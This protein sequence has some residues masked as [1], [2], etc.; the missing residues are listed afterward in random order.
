MKWTRVSCN[1]GPRLLAGALVLALSGLM[2]FAAVAGRE[3]PPAVQVGIDAGDIGR[4][5][6][7]RVPYPLGFHAKGFDGRIDDPKA[8]WTG[9]GLWSASG[10]RTP[11]LREGGK[12]SKP[13]VAHFQLRPDPVSK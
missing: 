13:L 9:R 3:R 7:L 4:M 5:I 11:W 10:D 12:G 2:P 8:G 6:I 1:P